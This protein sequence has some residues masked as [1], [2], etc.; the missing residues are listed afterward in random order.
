MRL[1]PIPPEK[2]SAEQRPLYDRIVDGIRRYF[3][4]FISTREDGALVGV[5]NPLVRFPQFG[6]AA[7]DYIMA[8]SEHS[9]LPR[10]PHEVAILVVGAHFSSR[11]Q[12]YAHEHVAAM[13]CLSAAKIATI[14]A[15][16]R[17]SDL[18]REEGVAYDVASR[19]VRGGQLP[20]AIYQV[21]LSTFGE[22]GVA[23]LV[24]LIGGYCFIAAILNAWDVAVPGSGEPCG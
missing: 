9:T 19:L 1:D 4:G 3:K 5:F 23:E 2:L 6:G 22:Q 12:I 20:E 15:G 10:A 24:Y 11:Y 21:A 13:A 18:T 7:W 16:E 17:P 14:D 8:L